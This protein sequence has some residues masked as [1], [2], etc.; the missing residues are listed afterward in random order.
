MSE[1]LGVDADKRA[2]WRDICAKLSAYPLQQR[3][4]KTVFRYSEK[5]TAWWNDNTLGIQHI[6][7]AG[8]IGLDSEPKLLETSRNMID[9]MGRWKDFNGSSSWYAACARV[10][11]NPEV[12]LT[13]MRGMYDGHA[14]PNKLLTFGGG[15][16]EN[17]SPSLAVTEMLMQSHAGVLRVFPCWPARLDARFGFLR[18]VG[19]FL[20]SAELKGGKISRLKIVSEKGN[21]CTLVNPWLDKP[22]HVTRSGRPAETVQGPRITLHTTAGETLELNP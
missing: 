22:V 4:G 3:D 6:F 17:V 14:M 21:D 8:T 10:G 20:V 16:I 9:A 2:K 19:A 12:I 13:E 1:A 7:P 18:A 11:Y 5:G 15:G